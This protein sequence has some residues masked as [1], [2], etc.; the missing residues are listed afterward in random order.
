MALLAGS[1]GCGFNASHGSADAAVDA[2]DAPPDAPVKTAWKYVDTSDGTYWSASTLY[3]IGP[4]L[5]VTANK[6]IDTDA[7]TECKVV[8]VDIMSS[9]K[10]TRVEVCAVFAA[11]ISIHAGVT[12]SAHGALPLALFAPKIDVQGT[13]DVASRIGGQRGAGSTNEGCNPSPASTGAG[14]GAGGTWNIQGGTGGD[15]GG[16]PGTGGKVEHAI[17]ASLLRVGCDGLRGGDGSASGGDDTAVGGGKGGGGVWIATD[18][19]TDDSPL[20][21]GMLT[22][23]AISVINASGAS[24][25]GASMGG[26]GGS[27]GGSGGLIVLQSKTYTQDPGARIFAAGGHGGGGSSVLAAGA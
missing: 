22:L 19:T 3:G 13:I 12:L 7:K 18:R 21:G 16:T 26:R 2:I 27:G 8:E 6:V 14:G 17:A 1:L 4:A 15:Q 25:G 11:S 10:S 5:D 9:D 23:G 24:G 20:I